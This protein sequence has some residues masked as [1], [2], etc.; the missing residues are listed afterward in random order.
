MKQVVIFKRRTNILSINFG[1]D[2]SE[3]TITS[4]IRADKTADSPLIATWNFSFLTDGKDGEGLFT[5]D[6]SVASLITKSKGYMDVKRVT[7]GE[8]VPVFDDPIEVII[9]DSVTA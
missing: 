3:D 4:E 7:G 8:P 1:I 9:K 2:I 5:L 6:D